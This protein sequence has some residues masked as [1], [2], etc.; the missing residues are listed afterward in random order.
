MDERPYILSQ[1]YALVENLNAASKAMQSSSID[2]R[3]RS[4][5]QVRFNATIDPM[6]QDLIDLRDSVI[7]GEPLDDCWDRLSRTRS[8]CRPVFRECL[9]F[10]EGSLIRSAGIDVG[11]C[12]ISD[13]LLNDLEAMTNIHWA[14]LTILGER[15]SFDQTIDIMRLRFPEFGVWNLPLMAHE[16]GHLVEFELRALPRR[17]LFPIKVRIRQEEMRDHIKGKHL[18]ELF[19]DLFGVYSMGPA[20]AFAC[21]ILNFNPQKSHCDGEYHPSFAKRAHFIFRALEKMDADSP[22]HPFSS[23]I[24]DLESSWK[25]SL[26]ALGKSELSQEDK[27]QLD[28][29]LEELYVML[30]KRLRD[31]KYPTS[32]K[33]GWIV[34]Q[35]WFGVWDRQFGNKEELSIDGNLP[36]GKLRD[37]LNAA[38]LCRFRY[39][40]KVQEIS[41]ASQSLLREILLHK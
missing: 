24:Q 30:D 8:E 31:V 6:R 41:R 32:G 38:W 26:N 12:Q 18:R 35:N 19:C 4:A 11:I 37:M 13:A 15:E 36:K 1:I 2:E 33:D 20:F 23:A 7:G 27:D 28:I 25:K 21:L 39:P 29:W 3:L 10:I 17:D 9:D 40:D 34:A 16:F 5:V 22:G 14:R